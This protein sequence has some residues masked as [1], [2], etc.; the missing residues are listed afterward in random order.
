MNTNVHQTT[1]FTQRHALAGLNVMA[2]QVDAIFEAV[3]PATA[4]QIDSNLRAQ[5]KATP[6]GTIH[7]TD[8]HRYRH[9]ADGLAV[10]S[11]VNGETTGEVVILDADIAAAKAVVG[12]DASVK[13]ADALHIETL[14]KNPRTPRAIAIGDRF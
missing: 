8:L 6:S 4:K 13:L 5:A 7:E 2:A 11:G 3:S 1:E 10:V 9:L 12:T 14:K